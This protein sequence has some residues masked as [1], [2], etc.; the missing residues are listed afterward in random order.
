MTMVRQGACRAGCGAC[1]THLRLQV[2]REYATDPDIKH[3]IELHGI[4]VRELDG[5]AFAFLPQP[6]SALQA[7]KSCGLH[8]SDAKPA[9][10]NAFPATPQALLGL[11][12]CGYSFVEAA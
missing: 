11:D 1:C 7:D 3:W 10:C 12:D 8:G 9:L 6:C 2:P 5:G 4:A